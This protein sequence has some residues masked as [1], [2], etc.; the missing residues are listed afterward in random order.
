MNNLFKILCSLPIILVAL[1]FVPF[2][3]VCLLLF[4]YYVYRS[5]K[6]YYSFL[7]CLILCGFLILV[8]EMVVSIIKI[9]NLNIKIPYLSS[10]IT[11][12]IYAK[13]LQYSKLIITVGIIFLILSFIF[14]NIFITMTTKLN[15]AMRNYIQ[16]EEQRD[17]AIKK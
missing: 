5:T 10:I 13:L 3:G 2:L 8:P 7:L 9:L 6:K 4:R 11:S 12:D 17:Y 1:Y 15:S 16:Q 14:K